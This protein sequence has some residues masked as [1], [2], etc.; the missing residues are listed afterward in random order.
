MTTPA[1]SK[2]VEAIQAVPDPRRQCKNLRHRLVDVVILGFA[3]VLCG[4]DDFVEIEAF[5]HS[6]ADWFRRFLELPHGIPSH[7]TFRRVF[8][9]ICP[10]A[11][12]RCLIAWLQGLR[13]TAP[14]AA[15]AGEVVAIDGKTLRRTFDHARGLGALHLVSAW[16][17]ANGLTLGQVAVDAHSNEITAIPQLLELLDLKDCVVTID[18]AGCQKEIAAQIVA[19]EA[20]YVLAVKDNQPT[21]HEQVMDY[22]LQQLEADPAQGT[23]RRHRQV[24]TGHG[25]T[26]TRETFAVPASKEMV[27]TGTWTGLASLI[28]VIR[29][30]TD[31]ATGKATDEVRYFISS[32]PAKVKR[33][34]SAVRQHWGIENGL[35]WVLDV[36]FNEDR[37][38]QQERKGIENVAL[39][40]RLAVSLLRQDQTIKAGVK[41]KRKTAGWDND[42]LLHLL[43]DYH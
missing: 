27:A 1:Q 18:A 32:L 8:Q 26:E 30:C 4:C 40:N 31:H 14:A 43:F 29:Y 41:C 16:A 19:K 21:L 36:A 39:L 35:H 42:Y 3:G 24:E 17:S 22:F 6:K 2:L 9:A 7:D 33:L 25:R 13:P 23:L 38:R 20:D 37:M 5:A 10:L 28:M 15:G 11:L 12:Q 34:A